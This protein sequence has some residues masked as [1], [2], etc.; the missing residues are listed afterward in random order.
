MGQVQTLIE[1]Q[2]PTH[3]SEH[4]ANVPDLDCP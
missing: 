1:A 3:S 4:R 2:G